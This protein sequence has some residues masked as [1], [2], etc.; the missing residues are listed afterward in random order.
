M[1]SRKII[2]KVCGE[3]LTSMHPEDISMGFHRRVVQIKAKKP[4]DHEIKFFEGPSLDKL[5]ETKTEQLQSLMCDDCGVSIA[6][7]EPAVAT[8]MWRGDEPEAWEQEYNQ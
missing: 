1:S 7:G 6:D 8:T 3:K 5:T 2:C 4:D